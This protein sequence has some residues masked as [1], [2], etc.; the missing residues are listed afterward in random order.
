MRKKERKKKEKEKEKKQNQI[1]REVRGDA[2]YFQRGLADKRISVAQEKEAL[3][4]D[5]LHHFIGN[6]GRVCIM[7]GHGRSLGVEQ[8]F[9]LL[10][11]GST[12]SS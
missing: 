5:G 7:L 2:Q 6:L 12:P 3:L 4:L 11:I 10:H 8:G 1:D 9:L